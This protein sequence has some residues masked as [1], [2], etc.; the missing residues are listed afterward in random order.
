MSNPKIYQVQEHYLVRADYQVQR[1]GE[2]ETRNWDVYIA[3]KDEEYFGKAELKDGEKLI[4]SIPW[5]SLNNKEISPLDEII[6][7]MKTAFEQ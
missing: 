3:S 7:I 5:V 4:R 2:V 1:T 6:Q